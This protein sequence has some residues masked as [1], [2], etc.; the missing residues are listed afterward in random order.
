[1]EKIK[2]VQIKTT[3]SNTYKISSVVDKH[4]VIIDQPIEA[5]GENLGPT[6]LQYFL[7]AIAGCIGTIAK[8]VAKQKNITIYKMEI[9]IHGDLDVMVLLGRSTQNRP[10]F[11]SIEIAV[12]L[13]SD[14]PIDEEERF[15]KE[16]ERRCPVS[17]NVLNETPIVL[18]LRK[19]AQ[20]GV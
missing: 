3:Q 18:T 17:E 5:G 15:L 1:M 16:V 4:H 8:T 7:L 10:G 12:S 2:T 20:L 14:V 9:D 11:R 6:P 13:E 19:E